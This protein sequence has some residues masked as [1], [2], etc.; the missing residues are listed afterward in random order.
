VN[1]SDWSTVASLATALGTLILAIATF[2]AIRSANTSARV[3]ERALL[4]GLR[5]VL[6]PARREDPP[7][8]VN[9]GD[10]K[11]MMARGGTGAAEIGGGD[12]SLGPADDVIYLALAL[13][14]IG[15]GM[16]V[17]RAWRFTPGWTRDENHSPLADFRRQTRDLYVPASDIGYWQGAIR[18]KADQQYTDARTVIEDMEAWTVELLY[19]D[20][21]GGQR[22]ITRIS[23]LPYENQ[24]TREAHWVASVSRYWNL[25]RPDPR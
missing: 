7:I 17:L 15:S 8:K 12:G 14:N 21:E 10:G 11:W 9:F 23:M 19:G 13:R 3:A 6:A 22:V 24:E 5:P 20:I 25:D 4:E 18:D 16:G 2:A 1:L